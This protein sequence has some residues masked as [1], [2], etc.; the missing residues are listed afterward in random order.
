M[1]TL[2]RAGF[3]RTTQSN[4]SSR[5]SGATTPTPS[6]ASSRTATA[7]AVSGHDAI[8]SSSERSGGAACPNASSYQRWTRRLV[9]DLPL[10]GQVPPQRGAA[11]TP[12]RCRAR[13]LRARSTPRP[14]RP[15][16]THSRNRAACP[17]R[18]CGPRPP[19]CRRPGARGSA[20]RGGPS[21]ARAWHGR[22]RRAF[23]RAA[24]PPQSVESRI[25]C[26]PQR[27]PRRPRPPERGAVRL[28]AERPARR[29]TSPLPEHPPGGA[30]RW[31]RH[32]NAV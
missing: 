31:H 1:L 26:R 17:R 13:C 9:H 32:C 18:R 21:S 8:P 22:S 19:R 25:H 29:T 4:R 20:P 6:S 28:G 23:P 10:R 16:A 3:L 5:P 15:G 14:R 7:V 30:G 2:A 27:P 24:H 11:R 12:R